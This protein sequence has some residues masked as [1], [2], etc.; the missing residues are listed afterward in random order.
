MAFSVRSISPLGNGKVLPAGL[1]R[2]FPLALG[3]GDLFLLTRCGGDE[4]GPAGLTG[5]V[6]RSSHRLGDEA[7]TLGGGRLPLQSLAGQKGVAFAGIAD[8]EGF[9]QDLRAAGLHLDKTLAFPD[10]AAYGPQELARL[11]DAAAG[12]DYLMTTE[13]DGVKLCEQDF[14]IPCYQVPLTLHFFEPG[15][16]EERLS[17]LFQEKTMALSKELLE[18]IACPKCKGE[19]KLRGEGDALVCD[20]CRLAYPVRDD[21]PVML[22]DEAQSLDPA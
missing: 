10:H 14:S 12:C 21:I 1:L 13:K 15:R 5:P 6:L 3:R 16:L 11:A 8:P 22:I 19:V 2:E 9:F 17:A 7:V 4:P 20:A 18:I